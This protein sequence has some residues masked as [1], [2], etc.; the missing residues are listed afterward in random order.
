MPIVGF[1]LNCSGKNTYPIDVVYTWVDSSDPEWDKQKN[2]YDG[3]TCEKGRF[4]PVDTPDIE[5]ET[6]L[7][8]LFKF[9]PFINHVYIVTAD[10]QIP[11]CITTNKLL[12]D[13]PI[14]VVHHSEIWPDDM[15][16]TLPVFN[17]FSIEANI[18]R[19][20]NLSE[21]FIYFNDDMYVV[22]P[23][24][25]SDC[26]V[27]NKPIVQPMGRRKPSY[28]P[29]HYHGAWKKLMTDYYPINTPWHSFHC[30][31]KSTVIQAEQVGGEDWV[32]TIGS[33]LRNSNDMPTIGFSINYALHNDLAYL[34]IKPLS[35]L[36]INYGEYVYNENCT[37][38][39]VCINYTNDAQRDAIDLRKHLL[40][41]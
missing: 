6:S 14:T 28:A 25:E 22:N 34:S 23:I 35:L 4:P 36:L 33:R 15:L 20:P 3:G 7:L 27:N 41:T 11:P 5:L 10:K 24:S 13:K 39:V 21:L 12:S 37:Y 32:R 17:S 1:P 31:N 8:L 26:F 19:I 29:T 38:H 16:H 2:F 40:L 9:M 30:L 18:H